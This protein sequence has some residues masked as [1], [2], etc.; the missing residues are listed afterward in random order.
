MFAFVLTSD[1]GGTGKS[2]RNASAAPPKFAVTCGVHSFDDRNE[3]R[4]R[5]DREKHSQPPSSVFSSN[6]PRRGA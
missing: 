6:R 1:R 3:S 4:A 2:R 5:N